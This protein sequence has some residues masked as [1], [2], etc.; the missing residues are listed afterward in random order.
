MVIATLP[1]LLTLGVMEWQLHTFS[2]RASSALSNSRN[3]SVFTRRV[4]SSYLR[5]VGTYGAALAVLSIT[6]LVVGHIRHAS[7]NTL[8]LL[9][10]A[11][12]T[13]GVTFFVT[14][15]LSSVGHINLVLLYWAGTFAVL[16]ATLLGL[17]EVDGAVSAAAGITVLLAATAVAATALS[18]QAMRILTDSINY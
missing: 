16:G 14:L 3:I 4:R 12:G 6:G 17:R 11:V 18:I 8:L 1:L 9:T 5:A 7:M 2:S 13:I 15:L 10:L